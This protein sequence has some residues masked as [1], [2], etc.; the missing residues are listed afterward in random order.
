ML[1]FNRRPVRRA[2]DDAEMGIR[3]FGKKSVAVSTVLFF[4]IPAGAQ[5]SCRHKKRQPGPQKVVEEHMAAFS[6]CDWNRLLAGFADNAE[7]FAPNG[8]VVR[9]RKALNQLYATV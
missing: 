7:F 9:G 4:A 6:A 5:E 8:A 2:D 1:S 3:L